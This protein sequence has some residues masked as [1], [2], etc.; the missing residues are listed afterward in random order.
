MKRPLAGIFWIESILG[1]AS[2][3]LLVLTLVWKD[4]IEIV[5]GIDPDNHSGSLEWLIV[6]MCLCI[7]VISSVAAR[8]EWRRAFDTQ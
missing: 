4:W 7:T 1:V 3:L 8:Q 2:T 5:F 6:I